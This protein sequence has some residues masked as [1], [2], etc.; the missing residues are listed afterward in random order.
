MLI[1]IPSRDGTDQDF[2]DPTRPVNFK[3]YAGLTGQSICFDPSGQPVFYGKFLF[4]EEKR[5]NLK[6]A[7]KKKHLKKKFQKGGA[8][9]EVLKLVTPDGSLTKNAIYF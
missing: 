2:F 4:T 8:M 9:C 3:I 5:K 6:K 1:L 7:P